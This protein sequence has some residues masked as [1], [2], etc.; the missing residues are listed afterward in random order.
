MFTWIQILGY[1]PM[2]INSVQK[3]RHLK[4]RKAN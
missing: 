1:I 3:A 2:E 4:H